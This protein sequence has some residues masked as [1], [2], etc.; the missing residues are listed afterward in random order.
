V[1]GVMGL[2]GAA[3]PPA[4]PIIVPVAATLAFAQWVSMVYKDA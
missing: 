4:A 3:V 2:V 1:T